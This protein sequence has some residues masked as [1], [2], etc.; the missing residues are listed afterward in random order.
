MKPDLEPAKIFAP[1]NES[2]E[3]WKEFWKD[4]GQ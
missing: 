4:S 2:D 3:S 1:N